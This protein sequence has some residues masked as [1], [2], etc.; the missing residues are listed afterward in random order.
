MSCNLEEA[1]DRV[2][3]CEK[4]MLEQDQKVITVVLCSFLIVCHKKT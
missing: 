2:I 4:Q 1:Q 3:M